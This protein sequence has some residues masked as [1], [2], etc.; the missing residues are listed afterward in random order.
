MIVKGN[1]DYWGICSTHCPNNQRLE[2][3]YIRYV[4]HANCIRCKFFVKR[5]SSN[6]I[7][8]SYETKEDRPK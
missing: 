8:C 3:G 7:E 5:I 1:V 4:C 2:N 6:E